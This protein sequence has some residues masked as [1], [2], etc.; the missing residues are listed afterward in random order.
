MRIMGLTC[1]GPDRPD[2]VLSHHHPTLNPTRV[3]AQSPRLARS[4]D[5]EIEV[6]LQV[7]VHL[8]F[9][10]AQC[11]VHIAS[12]IS[13]KVHTSKRSGRNHAPTV[14]LYV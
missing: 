13:G 12:T 5:D 10:I 1:S 6:V 14:K 9:I 4:R 2:E 8:A 11:R 3:S 7:R